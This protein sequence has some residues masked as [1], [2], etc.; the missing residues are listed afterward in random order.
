MIFLHTHPETRYHLLC[1]LPAQRGIFYCIGSEGADLGQGPSWLQNIKGALFIR[2]LHQFILCQHL[3]CLQILQTS[4][5]QLHLP[6]SSILGL[7]KTILG[8]FEQ[9]DNTLDLSFRVIDYAL[10]L[11]KRILFACWTTSELAHISWVSLLSQKIYFTVG[12][13]VFEVVYDMKLFS[14]LQ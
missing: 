7:K 5:Q 13:A 12:F 9:I 3:M 1:W 2:E 4:F 6:R 10:Y 8:F 14:R 11:F